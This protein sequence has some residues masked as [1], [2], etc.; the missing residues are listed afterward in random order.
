VQDTVTQA[1]GGEHFG[2]QDP[3]HMNYRN[4]PGYA[5]GAKA[6]NF[7][8]TTSNPRG[9]AERQ[10]LNN[11]DISARNTDYSQ[12][13]PPR[14]QEAYPS[15]TS[16]SNAY[17]TSARNMDYSQQMP[18]RN[19][20][21][22]SSRTAD[23]NAYGDSVP[24]QP[25]RLN[26]KRSMSIPRKSVGEI[27]ATGNAKQTLPSQER[28]DWSMT[29]NSVLGAASR[30]SSSL[31]GYTPSVSGDIR[32]GRQQIYK[33][34]FTVEGAAQPPSLHGIVD[35]TNTVDTTTD[36]VYAPGRSIQIWEYPRSTNVRQLSSKRSSIPPSTTFA[37]NSTPERSTTITF[38]SALSLSSTSKS[39][40][41][42]ILSRTE[43]DQTPC[44]LRSRQLLCLVVPRATLSSPKLLASSREML[45]GMPCLTVISQQGDSDL[46][47]EIPGSTSVKRACLRLSRLGSIHLD[48]LRPAVLLVRLYH[49]L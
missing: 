25:S 2:E 9:T 6:D 20:D 36:I 31:G 27:N 22:V 48:W 10:G 40:P 5:N 33:N 41:Q 28:N 47:K 34:A 23:S 38:T 37:K 4:G 21:G 12:Q 15:K 35:L 13:M 42:S 26:H 16:D 8:S 24:S 14:G 19:Q 45:T 17:N 44:T 11:D 46:K 32:R 1:V 39:Y 18:P 30:G 43:T 3:S 29:G 7:D 49:S